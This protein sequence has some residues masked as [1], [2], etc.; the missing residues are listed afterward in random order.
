MTAADLNNLGGSKKKG[1]Q[2]DVDYEEVEKEL[3]CKLLVYYTLVKLKKYEAQKNYLNRE[4][5]DFVSKN[6]LYQGFWRPEV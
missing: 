3:N 6:K 4:I 2:K 1:Q 5:G